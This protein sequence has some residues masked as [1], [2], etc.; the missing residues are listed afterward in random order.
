[1]LHL[2]LRRIC[3]LLVGDCRIPYM[4]VDQVHWQ[5]Y[6]SQ[7]YL[8]WFSASLICQLLKEEH[9]SPNY[10]RLIYFVL[11]FYRSL[12][13]GFNGLLQGTFLGFCFVFLFFEN[14]CIHIHAVSVFV[15]DNFPCSEVGF[16]WNMTTLASFCVLWYF[17]LF[18]YF[19]SICVFKVGFL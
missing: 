8:Y 11:Q 17:F 3:I 12:T 6:S 5:C 19:Y 13:W 2:T 10:N 14:R 15:P 7:L 1:M 16:V 18:L 9:W 4:T